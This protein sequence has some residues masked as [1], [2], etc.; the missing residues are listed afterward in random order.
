MRDGMLTISDLM[1]L[2]QLEYAEFAFLSACET[3]RGDDGSMN[4]S[5]HLA[6][7]LQN[8]GFASVIG[9]MWCVSD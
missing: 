7:A 8:I 3:A 2:E 6:A 1:K 4:Q 5:V 9:T